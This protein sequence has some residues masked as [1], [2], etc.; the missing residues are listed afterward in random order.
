MVEL[1]PLLF[2]LI[3][4][5]TTN[6]TFGSG[7]KLFDEKRSMEKIDGSYSR[8]DLI[9]KLD[10]KPDDEFNFDTTIYS[11]I[12]KYNGEEFHRY[13]IGIQNDVENI[14]YY[15]NSFGNLEKIFKLSEKEIKNFNPKLPK[16]PK[17]V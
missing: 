14:F 9:E 8:M 1:R 15:F 2:G 4:F 16:C 7:A 11:I 10:L 12:C 6:A 17:M 3:C 5:L 13:T